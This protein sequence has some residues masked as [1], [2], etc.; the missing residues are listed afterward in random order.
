MLLQ[1]GQEW[2]FVFLITLFEK[3]TKQEMGCLPGW[4]RENLPYT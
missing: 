2:A 3:E 1:E 4:S